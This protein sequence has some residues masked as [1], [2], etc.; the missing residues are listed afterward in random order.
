[1]NKYPLLTFMAAIFTAL[2]VGW[3]TWHLTG[4]ITA[5]V[6]FAVVTFAF[7]LHLDSLRSR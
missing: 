7:Y 6:M 2:S 5:S 1:M 4:D 3:G